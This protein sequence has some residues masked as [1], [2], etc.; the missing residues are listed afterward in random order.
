MHNKYLL[1]LSA[2]VAI[3]PVV[4]LVCALVYVFCSSVWNRKRPDASIGKKE[5]LS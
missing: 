5:T 1:I 3:T 2:I 4:A